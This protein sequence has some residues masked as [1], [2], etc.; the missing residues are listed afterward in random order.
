MADFL[1]YK[2]SHWLDESYDSLQTFIDSYNSESLTYLQKY[3]IIKYLV[4]L[5]PDNQLSKI[6]L[7]LVQNEV[8]LQPKESRR[9]LL[10]KL[11]NLLDKWEGL[12]NSKK[13][14]IRDWADDV[15]SYI[16]P[17][18]II[19]FKEKLTNKYT[20]RYQRGDI[21]SV[22]P[23]GTIIEPPSIENKCVAL[24]IPDLSYDNAKSYDSPLYDDQLNMVRKRKYQLLWADLP[25]TMKDSFIDNRFLIT[26]RSE[27]NPYIQEHLNG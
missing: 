10:L 7:L 21:V 20:S 19:S 8:I 14:N 9:S 17:E 15:I 27:I 16:T 22:Y 3:K 25:Q 11:D 4:T 12:S 18:M 2:T 24:R 23:T 13:Q 26:T 6:I 5:V 1:I